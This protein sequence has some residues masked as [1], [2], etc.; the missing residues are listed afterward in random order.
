MTFHANH[1]QLKRIEYVL[2]NT[3]END[4]VYDGDIQ[5]NVFR[6][7]LHY[8]WYS[9]KNGGLRTYNK[10]TNNKF[11]DYDIVKLILENQPLLISNFC[12]EGSATPAGSV[13]SKFYKKTNYKN[14]YIKK[15][16]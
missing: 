6:P 13:L 3:G 4:P 10:I 15:Q 16:P 2:E 5:F 12:L 7:D 1:K 8:F 9:I 14:L 11:G